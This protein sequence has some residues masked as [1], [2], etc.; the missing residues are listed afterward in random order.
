MRRPGLSLAQGILGAGAGL[1]PGERVMRVRKRHAWGAVLIALFVL[2]VLKPAGIPA[3]ERPVA[4]F[5]AWFGRLPAL[6]PRLWAGDD[7][8]GEVSDDP[9]ARSLE[10]ENALLREHYAER[11]QVEKDAAALVGTLEASGLDRLPRAVVVRVLRGADVSGT[12]RS[13]LIDHG[14]VD[15][16]REGMAVVSGS[17]F[18]GRVEIVHAR[19][20]LVKLLTDR[21]SR[22]EVALRTD[23]GVRVT[24]YVRGY[25][26]GSLDEDLD[27]RHVHVDSGIGRVLPGTPVVT[28]NAD[29]LVPAGLLIG[30][31]TDVVDHDRDD[32]PVIRVR[33]ALD[34][35]RSTHAIVLLPP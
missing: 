26:R 2:P 19:S 27:V 11:L 18:V 31:V 4:S 13:L 30:H 15:G 24:G 22:Q 29:A 17:V 8:A 9:R 33:P 32:L 34:L 25:G 10:V 12:R 7:A 23:A 16:V 20:A 35:S 6:N 28:S 3:L 1:L 5:F 21:R 14:S